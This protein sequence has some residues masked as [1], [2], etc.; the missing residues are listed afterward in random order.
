MR[1]PLLVA[2]LILAA[3]PLQ[4]GDTISRT[5]HLEQDL[6]VLENLSRRSVEP[7]M[8]TIV[9]GSRA[10]NFSF[11][12]PDAV[13]RTL[14]DLLE[15]GAILLTFAPHADALSAIEREREQLLDMGVIPVA[16]IEASSRGTKSS[17]KK[18]D[19]HYT[20]IPDPRSVIAEQFNS[21]EPTTRHTQPSWFVIDRRGKV[22]SLDRTGLPD[23]GFASIAGKAL[24][25]PMP[26]IALPASD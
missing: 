15:Q 6:S 24:A 18:L 13:W 8:A 21:L 20:V 23:D 17:I 5:R 2:G 16:V 26:G 1:L 25:I 9:P 19:L 10:P 3:N 12:A 22:R 4:L 14:N 7:G 11:Q